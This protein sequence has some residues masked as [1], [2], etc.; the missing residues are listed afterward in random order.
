[1]WRGSEGVREE[2]REGLDV[3]DKG[4]R[5]LET[6]CI[7]QRPL[8]DLEMMEQMGFCS[9]IENYSRHLS[10]RKAGEPP[11]TLLDYFP[12]D[13]LLVIDE[14]P[15]TMPQVQAM[16]RGDRARKETLVEY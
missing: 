9:G 1:M 13:F 15:Q 6:Q 12:P 11:P 16:Y 5:F 4:G 8:Y 3:F 14:S 7:Q 10:G 2:V